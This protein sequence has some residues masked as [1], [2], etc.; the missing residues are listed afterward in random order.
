MSTVIKLE[1]A[2]ELSDVPLLIST[3]GKDIS[4]I[5]KGEP[6]IGKSSVL[7]MLE[8]MHG[9]KYD[10]IYVDCPVLDL[11]DVVMR[12]PNHETKSLE[13]YVS[14]LFRLDSP[15]PKIIMLDE[16]SK[17]NKL[18]QT[19]F[20]RLLLEHCV[21]DNDL[22]KTHPESIIY[23]TGNHSS[24]GVGDSMLAHAGNRVMIV[25]VNKPRAVA[26]NLWASANGISR[27]LRAWVA[28]NPRCL[29]SVY[30]G[31]QDD[32]EFILKPGKGMLSYV[33]NRSLAKVDTVIKN[34]NKFTSKVFK[35]AL[36]GTCG[37][38]F[39]N[40]FDGFFKMEKQ[41][42]P[43][44]DIVANPLDIAMPDNPA[45]LFM[46]MFNAIDTIETQDDLS[47]FMKFVNRI[48]S[49]EVQECFFTMAL[50]GRL[51]KLASRNDDIKA[52]GVKNLSLMM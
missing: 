6:G 11:S 13:S 19:M 33:S 44:K 50:Q 9:N 46:T 41:L 31:G 43:V 51:A 5:L 47:S 48:K 22:K 45:V 52:W 20:T 1:E 25:N 27:S 8:E 16:F 4:V 39:A 26:W 34:A 30:D 37:M 42:V 23:G 40:S 49:T 29:A 35:V 14:A 36:A 10:Y 2:I 18:L 38:A 15:K 7:K 32:N 28:M 12:I 17:T 3:V 24:D 21:G